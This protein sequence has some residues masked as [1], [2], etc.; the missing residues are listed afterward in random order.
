MREKKGG[1]RAAF[2][3]SQRAVTPRQLHNRRADK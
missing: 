3:Q 1:E 2:C